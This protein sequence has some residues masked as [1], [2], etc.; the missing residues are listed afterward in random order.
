MKRR[1]R[2]E[3]ITFISL[4]FV[5]LVLGMLTLFGLKLI[6]IYLES[7]KIDSGLQGV[8][9]DSAVSAMTAA[10]IRESL[11][12]RWDIDSVTRI[13]HNNF[14]KYVKIAKQKGRVSINVEY[15]AAAPLFRNLTLVAHFNKSVSN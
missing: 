7:W 8:I 9:Q 6:P 4:V 13:N 15:D 1:N 5:L 12:R 11:L 14:Q 2:E 10:E 3:G